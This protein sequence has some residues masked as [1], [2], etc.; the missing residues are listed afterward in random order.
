M[1]AGTGKPLTGGGLSPSYIPRAGLGPALL[2]HLN[3]KQKLLM[4]PAAVGLPCDF[5]SVACRYRMNCSE[6]GCKNAL[7]GAGDPQLGGVWGC[8]P[9]ETSSGG[10]WW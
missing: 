5:A 3:S 9:P 1:A 7:V 6:P 2:Q 10:W 8:G 4:Q